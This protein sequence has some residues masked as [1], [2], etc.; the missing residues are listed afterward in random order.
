MRSTFDGAWRDRA[1]AGDPE[2]V[3]GLAAEALEPLYAFALYRVGGDR[4]LCEEVVQET[5]VRA[6]RDLSQ[7]DPDRAEG[8]PFGWL[9]GM[10]RN[11]IQRV[12]ARR[13]RGTSLE[14]LRERMDR[15]LLDV[16]AR[17]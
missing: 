10:A 17:L 5:L 9:T 8:D 2:A 12:L 15:E 6:I 13:R 14:T 4:D 11:E 1:M 16:Y 3:T 7:Y